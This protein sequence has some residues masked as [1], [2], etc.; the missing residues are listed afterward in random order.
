MIELLKSLDVKLFL[1]LNAQN[2]PVFDKIMWFISGKLEWIPLYLALIFWLFYRFRKK[3]WLMLGLGILVIALSDLGSVHLFKNVFLRYRPSHNP[4]LEGVIHLV[5]N[6]HG[7]WYGFI[8][9]HA[10]NTFGLAVIMS[11]YFKDRWFVISILIWAAIVSYS[12]IYLGVHYP[13]DVLCGAIWGSLMAGGVYFF[14]KKFNTSKAKP[15]AES[16]VQG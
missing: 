10:A 6:Y 16:N 9:S 2:S 8:S 13:L 14:Y 11:L 5:N 3:G 1:F 4:E 12:R 7:G 15:F